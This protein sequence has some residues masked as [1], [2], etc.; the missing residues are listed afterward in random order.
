[1]ASTH[2][3]VPSPANSTPASRLADATLDMQLKMISNTSE[4]EHLRS[5]PGE[6]PDRRQSPPAQTRQERQNTG[7]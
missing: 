7:I 1:M 2:P 6:R 4:E 3:L 5:S